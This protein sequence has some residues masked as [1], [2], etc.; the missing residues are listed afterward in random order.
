M[1]FPY[2]N[3][4]GGGID[5]KTGIRHLVKPIDVRAKQV[6]IGNSRHY[7]ERQ[8]QT[9]VRFRRPSTRNDGCGRVEVN[10]GGHACAGNNRGYAGCKSSPAYKITEGDF[11]KYVIDVDALKNCLALLPK[12]VNIEGSEAIY[13]KDAFDMIDAFPKEEVKKNEVLLRQ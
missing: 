3:I 9:P 4:C 7:N 11:M 5:R 12:M 10:S 6:K 13:I 2:L 1:G 8:A